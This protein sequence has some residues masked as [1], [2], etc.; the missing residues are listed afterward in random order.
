MWHVTA[1]LDLLLLLPYHLC[2]TSTIKRINRCSE[3]SCIEMCTE[4]RDGTN[5]QILRT[6]SNTILKYIKNVGSCTTETC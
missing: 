1:L 4:S 2:V 5:E 3:Y 6:A